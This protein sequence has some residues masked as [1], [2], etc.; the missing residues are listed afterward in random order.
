[1]TD[2]RKRGL[3]GLY[4]LLVLFA[5]M[6]LFGGPAIVRMI[7]IILFGQCNVA[8]EAN[9]MKGA[10]EE[11]CRGEIGDSKQVDYPSCPVFM[12]CDNCATAAGKAV[13]RSVLGAAQVVQFGKNL[14]ATWNAGKNIATSVKT[15]KTFLSD[16][17]Y[18]LSD[19]GGWTRVSSWKE[20]YKYASWD[21][22]PIRAGYPHFDALR[23]EASALTPVI[24][25]GDTSTLTAW[26]SI[27]T[28]AMSILTGITTVG[29]SNAG[30]MQLVRRAPVTT[31]YY[32]IAAD[33]D[34]LRPDIQAKVAAL[35]NDVVENTESIL[36]DPQGGSECKSQGTVIVPI[37]LD[38]YLITKKEA[39]TNGDL[40][41]LATESGDAAG[42]ANEFL[43]ELNTKLI[44]LFTSVNDQVYANA[45]FGQDSCT[46][47]T[48]SGFNSVP[49]SYSEVQGAC[50][51]TST[52]VALGGEDCGE[53]ADANFSK[54]TNPLSVAEQ[55]D[56]VDR[57]A[58]LFIRRNH[59]FRFIDDLRGFLLNR[60]DAVAKKVPASKTEIMAA[61]ASIESTL[62]DASKVASNVTDPWYIA[63]VSMGAVAGEV[64]TLAQYEQQSANVSVENSLISW[65]KGAFD[66]MSSIRE[67]I[68]RLK[69]SHTEL[70]KS[71]NKAF[72]ILSNLPEES[73]EKKSDV[74]SPGTP[75]EMTVTV[76][77]CSLISSCNQDDRTVSQTG[78]CLIAAANLEKGRVKVGDV[79]FSMPAIPI[80]PID[81]GTTINDLQ[82]PIGLVSGLIGGEAGKALATA[83][84]SRRVCKG[85][86]SEKTLIFCMK[87]ASP[88][89][90]LPGGCEVCFAAKCNTKITCTSVGAA[91]LR[92]EKKRDGSETI[93]ELTGPV[94]P[95]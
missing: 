73:C 43:F 94:K 12:K 38:V 1:M 55:D 67:L 30:S 66:S 57:S 60:A 90:A 2:G 33:P 25:A 81:Y 86:P 45:A 24:V 23:T 71:R 53:P 83:E 62:K 70:L 82:V 65:Y 63:Y 52:V 14:K 54:C 22:G 80:A 7:N 4:I 42:E 6:I 44:S 26:Q 50:T 27:G 64:A 76:P 36:C 75:G 17:R 87:P 95:I 69:E 88:V 47:P 41:Q 56:A 74:I 58:E 9:K 16:F 77:M 20:A 21:A 18:G 11:V 84:F 35:T 72:D 8:P 39:D 28:R 3:S 93:T 68:S 78:G 59:A 92:V 10:I 89:C 31:T 91:N 29:S 40:A 5:V 13:F 34:G 85:S 79:Y 32:Y 48:S 15:A 37:G 49:S 19:A 46:Q 61:R 51:L